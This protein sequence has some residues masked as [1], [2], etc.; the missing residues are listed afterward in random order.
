MKKFNY[1]KNFIR[2]SVLT[3]ALSALIGIIVFLIG[4]NGEL[5]RRFLLTSLAIGAYSVIGLCCSTIFHSNKLKVFSIAGMIVSILAFLSSLLL[6]WQIMMDDTI[7]K[8]V[9]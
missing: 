8:A 1:K 6:I 4:K 2:I 9:G 5:E 7:W 3:L